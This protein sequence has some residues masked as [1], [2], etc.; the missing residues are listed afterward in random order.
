MITHPSPTPVFTHDIYSLWKAEIQFFIPH[1]PLAT[2]SQFWAAGQHIKNPLKQIILLLPSRLISVTTKNSLLFWFCLHSLRTELGIMWSYPFPG[3]LVSS[4]DTS[5]TSFRVFKPVSWASFF[6]P[7]LP[8]LSLW[9]CAGTP[10]TEQ[11]ESREKLL[12]QQIS[13]LY[14][15]RSEHLHV[16]PAELSGIQKI[17]LSPSLKGWRH[18]I[19]HD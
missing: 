16:I 12:D 10:I 4:H 19:K 13:I 1:M 11:S 5:K 8:S 17:S 7:T 3:K 18:E 6:S 15:N 9:V 14:M 2:V